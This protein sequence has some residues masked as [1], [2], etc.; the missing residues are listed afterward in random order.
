MINIEHTDQTIDG[1]HLVF[2]EL[3]KFTPQTF[4]EKKMQVPWLRYLT[5]INEHTR[6]VSSEL[7]EDPHVKKALQ[8]LEEPAFS[9][10]QLEGYD[11]FWDMIRT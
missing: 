10:A 3:P 9:P 2:V 6:E 4:S 7:T 11:H 8:A 1:F 5:E